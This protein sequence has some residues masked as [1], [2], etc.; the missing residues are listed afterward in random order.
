MSWRRLAPAPACSRRTTRSCLPTIPPGS[1]ARARPRRPGPTSW[2]RFL[3]DVRGIDERRR[4]PRGARHLSR[5]LLGPARARRQ[6]AA[7]PAARQ[8]RRAR[9]GR[10]A[11]TAEVCCG[12]GGTFC[13][14]YP[15][16]L[17][18]HGREE[19]RQHRRNRRRPAAGRR[20]RLP[21]E[22][23]RQAEAPGPH[24][25]GAPRRRGAGRR[26]STSPPIGAAPRDR[27]SMH[28]TSHAFKEQCPRS[29]RR[30]RSCSGRSPGC[31]PASSRKRDSGARRA[32]GV[33]GAAR[34]R[35]ATSRTTRWRT[36]ISISRRTRRRSTAAG[37]KVHWAATAADARDDRPRDLPR[38]R[39]QA[40]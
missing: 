11:R 33:R 32:A 28:A 31:R 40:R 22:H 14:K 17:Q 18:R 39:R 8:R 4:Q 15:G 5:Q 27:R 36:S 2:S 37:G 7:A 21:H 12:F 38:R 13:V 3:A 35:R 29:A 9:A 26:L 30:C 34:H 19:A 25:R 24:D 1:A 16:H 23:G 10:D 6:G 20:S